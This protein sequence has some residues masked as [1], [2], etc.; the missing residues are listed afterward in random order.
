MGYSSSR[1]E[2]EELGMK[3]LKM[4]IVRRQEIRVSRESRRQ[5]S[6]WRES[7]NSSGWRKS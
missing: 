5:S 4:K 3:S 6:T 7:L 2:A 1:K